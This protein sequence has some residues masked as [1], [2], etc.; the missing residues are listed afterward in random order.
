M[1]GKESQAGV[2]DIPLHSAQAPKRAESQALPI[3]LVRWI[4]DRRE[5]AD[6]MI[7]AK[8]MRA[9]QPEL[10]EKKERPLNRRMCSGRG[11]E[12]R[13]PG[14]VG[15]DGNGLD[16]AARRDVETYISGTSRLREPATS[17]TDGRLVQEC[18]H[19]APPP[20]TSEPSSSGRYHGRS[21]HCQ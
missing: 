9:R 15:V 4:M 16:V 3:E 5:S 10:R 1:P 17:M 11:D 12:R 6:L 14:I 18:A 19:F 8:A 21:L 13:R 2:R 20:F 7:A